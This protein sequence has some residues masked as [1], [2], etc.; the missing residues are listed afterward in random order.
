MVDHHV[1]FSVWARARTR[2]SLSECNS[3]S[4]LV[5][6]LK[7]ALKKR[8]RASTSLSSM[9][10]PLVGKGLFIGKWPEEDVLKMNKSILDKELPLEIPIIIILNDLHSSF[11]NSSAL[12]LLDYIPEQHTGLFVEQD[13]FKA[14]IKLDSLDAHRMEDI[15]REACVDAA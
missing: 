8:E 11:C 4:S 12:K 15:I 2:V 14:A 7:K 1:H 3:M 10:E 13:A 6:E 9:K 5:E